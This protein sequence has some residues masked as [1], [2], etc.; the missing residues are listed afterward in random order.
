M[1]VWQR[2]N[3]RQNTAGLVVSRA[4]RPSCGL[5]MAKGGKSKKEVN[6]VGLGGKTGLL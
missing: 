2:L 3:G 1:L 6:V 5:R 4:E